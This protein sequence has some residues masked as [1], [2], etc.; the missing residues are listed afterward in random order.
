ME[1]TSQRHNVELEATSGG[2]HDSKVSQRNFSEKKNTTGKQQ[3]RER[4]SDRRSNNISQMDLTF[5]ARI[6]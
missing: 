4:V 5:R 1:K 3:H 6:A 2:K